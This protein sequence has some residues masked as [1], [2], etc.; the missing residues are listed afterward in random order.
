MV[1]YFPQWGIYDK[2]PYYVK[3]LVTNGSARRLDQINYS[4]GA[5]GGGR[6][7][8]ADVN[9]DLNTAFTA[10]TSVNGLADDPDSAFRGYFHQLQELK[11]RYP[12]LKVLISLEGKAA[13]FAEDAKP[14]NR[15]AFVASCV[16]MFIR[17]HFA[18]GVSK[19]G[20]FDGIDVDWESPQAGDAENFRALLQEFR[21]QMDAIRP[22]LRLAIAVD[23]APDTLTGTDF[24][25]VAKLVDQVGVM[26]Y[27]YAGPW[28]KTTGFLAPLFAPTKHS[29]SIE[30]SI[31]SYKRAGVPEHK[32]LMGVPFYGYGWE[33]V[34][35][36][37]NGLFQPGRAVHGDR[38]YRYIRTLSAPFATY[39]DPRSQAPWRFDG[40]T[41]WT[42]EDPISVRWKVSYARHQRLGGV[43][44]WELSQDT[45]DAELLSMVYRS[46]HHPLKEKEFA[47]L[48]TAE[49]TV[50]GS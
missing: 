15:R 50:A 44:I 27:D 36:A 28:S 41:F 14:E 47:K 40:E 30:R 2:Q 20:L 48:R 24:A 19:P 18:P 4:Q 13:D 39:R 12:R 26:N 22:G 33:A 45:A 42:Y 11:R 25:A 8:L 46:L 43:M 17:G 34:S 35:S 6:C 38:P 3:A 7:S 21:Q 31:A 37:N 16:D 10:E 5:V 23:E 1:G 32:L 49:T 29:L 9:A